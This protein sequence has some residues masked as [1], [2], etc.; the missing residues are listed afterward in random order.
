VFRNGRDIAPAKEERVRE[1]E[2][3][4]GY[5]MR[6]EERQTNMHA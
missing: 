5:E 6:E 3:E 1:R 4:R 2:R